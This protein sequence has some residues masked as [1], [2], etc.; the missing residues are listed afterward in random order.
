MPHGAPYWTRS[1]HEPPEPVHSPHS[2]IHPLA[3]ALAKLRAA[4]TGA[5]VKVLSEAPLVITVDG[6]LGPSGA[7]ALQA[8]P[9]V[10]AN[11]SMDG[12]AEVPNDAAKLADDYSKDSGVRTFRVS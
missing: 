10:V 9:A 3:D 5:T 12:E 1:V 8:L 6:F 4:K 7:T 11:R 2:K